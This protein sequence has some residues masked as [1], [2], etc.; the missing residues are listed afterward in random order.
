M[1]EE[2]TG[3]EAEAAG[4]DG[5]SA[6]DAARDNP[7]RWWARMKGSTSPHARRAVVNV[8]LTSS[9]SAMPSCRGSSSDN[10]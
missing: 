4:P 1:T 10:T 9:G 7:W 2:A 5:L 6:G 3:W 8:L